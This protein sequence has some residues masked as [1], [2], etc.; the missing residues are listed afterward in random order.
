MRSKKSRHKLVAISF[1]SNISLD[2]NYPGVGVQRSLPSSKAAIFDEDTECSSVS[3]SMVCQNQK[4]S[5]VDQYKDSSVPVYNL[6]SKKKLYRLSGIENTRH[7]VNSP[8]L[9]VLIT[10][11]S[12]N[13]PSDPVSSTINN[14]AV[15][16]PHESN[17]TD[18][19]LY[20]DKN[21]ITV[22]STSRTTRS[23]K[24][25]SPQQSGTTIVV[26]S[27]KAKNKTVNNSLPETYLSTSKRI[28]LLTPGSN[29]TN[30]LVIFSVIPYYG[31]TIGIALKVGRRA[32]LPNNAT[33]KSNLSC[34][35]TGVCAGA[36]YS[37][38]FTSPIALSKDIISENFSA[39]V[40]AL[41]SFRPIGDEIISYAHLLQ[42][43]PQLFT[44]TTTTS[45][46]C[47][48]AGNSNLIGHL[49]TQSAGSLFDMNNVRSCS[50]SGHNSKFVPSLHTINS[51]L[52]LHT[53]TATS[54][55]QMVTCEDSSL[56]PLATNLITF[57]HIKRAYFGTNTVNLP[58]TVNFTWPYSPN[59]FTRQ[60]N[61]STGSTT[62]T[63]STNSVT[64]FP[65]MVC[66]RTSAPGSSSMIIYPDPL[67]CYM[68]L[69]LDDPELLIATGKRVL[70]LPN[71]LTSV[72]GYVRPNEHKRD[73][74]REFHDRFPL[75]QL[76]LTKLRSIK[77]VMVQIARK[78]SFDLWIVAQ[79]HV[80]FEK[81]ILKLFIHKLNR[82]LCASAALL[83]SAKLNDI[84]GLELTN[85]IQE[86]E[87]NFRISRR[88]LM[89]TELDVAL[90]LEFCLIPTEF[91]IL[92]HYQR[93]YKSLDLTP[94]YLTD[95]NYNLHSR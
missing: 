40:P 52:G 86:L 26:E 23:V 76:T 92:P 36:T 29:E 17:I 43:S 9:S 20:V 54:S 87:T 73:V 60:R 34:D 14:R 22:V 95:I 83:I 72:L 2:G 42:P 91:E 7:D 5:L 18:K 71:Y 27:V 69:L 35:Q 62:H 67:T 77:S 81:L 84:K 13:R 79:A 59:F 33:Q 41:N 49:S 63:G 68:P 15:L 24:N 39:S 19:S 80:L 10:S 12:F 1:L 8:Q 90:G 50:T 32:L 53:P 61:A 65:N 94:P 82:K 89:N 51:A 4:V 66:S 11:C 16:P 31:K 46:R 44:P 85:L 38:S 28:A 45:V 70:K 6:E 58:S 93:I 74:N 48:S 88:D 37:H 55:V 78:L 56:I 64:N 57:S 25:Q 21:P 3:S 47:K 30:T 75:I